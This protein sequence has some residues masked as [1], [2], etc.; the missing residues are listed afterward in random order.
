LPADHASPRSG[1]A[2]TGL[3][4]AILG[5]GTG[6]FG[7]MQ[8]MVLPVL[9]DLQERYD[10][11]QSVGTWI[12][13]AYLLSATVATPLGGR[14]GDAFGKQRML[15]I[16]LS[17]LCIG[18]VIAAFAPSIEWLLFARVIQGLGGG[19][20]ALSFSIIRDEVPAAGAAQAIGLV[21]SVVSATFGLGMVLAGPIV[22]ALGI[23]GLFILPAVVTG[24]AALA[25]WKVIPPSPVRGPGR[26]SVTPAV[27]LAACLVTFLVGCSQGNA[28]GWL[29]MQILATFAASLTLTGAWVLAE[30]RA[31][32]PVI[33]LQLM[34]TRGIWTANLVVLLVGFSLFGSLGF[35]PQ[36]LQTPTDTGYGLGAS[37]SQTGLVLLPMCIISMLGGMVGPRLAR[38]FGARTVICLCVAFSA[39]AYASIAMWHS[40]L[41]LVAL[42]MCI[43]GMGSGAVA[44]SL[45]GVVLASAPAHQT[46]VASGMNANIRTIGGAIGSAMM[47]S[48]VTATVAAN[49]LP[50]EAGYRNGFLVLAAAMVVAIGAAL[51]IPSA[52]TRA[53]KR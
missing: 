17:M 39:V 45:A 6:S 26:I 46:G 47:G 19:V 53:A 1:G 21:S 9:A 31:S 15:I 25:A 29:S 28:Q 52:P 27:L 7:I 12:L 14:M 37:I 43:Q 4:L 33:D 8:S 51:A 16:S 41:E 49:G 35:L 5:V 50:T 18:S 23:R 13:T 32:A 42:F 20:V 2:R 10:V 3:T 36:L 40:S 22:D 38:R 48:V 24:V 44:A 30:R 34:R 11:S